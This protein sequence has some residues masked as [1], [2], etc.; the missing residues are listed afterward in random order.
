[1]VGGEDVYKRQA[2]P[3][4]TIVGSTAILNSENET[5]YY[6]YATGIKTGYTLAAGYCFICLL[7]TSRCV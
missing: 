2:H 6:R 1:M 3:R 7:Y 4:R 5:S